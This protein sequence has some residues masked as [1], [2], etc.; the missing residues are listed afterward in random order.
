MRRL[1]ASIPDIPAPLAWIS[2]LP[3]GAV[4]DNEGREQLGDELGENESE[5]MFAREQVPAVVSACDSPVPRPGTL[6]D[7]H[8]PGLL[9]ETACWWCAADKGARVSK[10][11]LSLSEASSSAVDGRL[12]WKMPG[13]WGTETCID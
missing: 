5:E 2:S 11:S 10:G 3:Y 4:D 6:L 1:S 13:I 12:L 8:W 9:P 7:R